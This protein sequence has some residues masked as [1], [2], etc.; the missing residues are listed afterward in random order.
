MQR[1]LDRFQ[2]SVVVLQCGADS[3]SGDRLGQYNLSMD[4][5]ADCVR[6]FRKTGLPLMLL[7]GGGYTIKNVARA[8]TYETA[9]ALN[10]DQDLDR[11]LPYNHYFE[12]FGPEYRLLVPVANLE[13]ANM[14]D[15][16]LD[17]MKRTVLSHAEEIPIAPS[18]QTQEV[19]RRGL[20]HELGLKKRPRKEGDPE[21]RDKDGDSE[22]EI[23]RVGANPTWDEFDHRIQGNARSLSLPSERIFLTDVSQTELAREVYAGESSESE[24][25]DDEL[26]EVDWDEHGSAHRNPKSQFTRGTVPLPSSSLLFRSTPQIQQ[27]NGKKSGPPKRKFFRSEIRFR[28]RGEIEL[29]FID[30]LRSGVCDPVGFDMEYPDEEDEDVLASPVDEGSEGDVEMEVEEGGGSGED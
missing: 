23:E 11:N 27:T 15:G 29:A 19:P 17:Q 25:E 3:L 30:G 13:D 5:H 26:R 24:T 1:I 16:H 9:C 22:E 8:W 21:K 20:A 28:S 12:W 7:G 14:A 4:G 18:V 10:I 6:F 2:P